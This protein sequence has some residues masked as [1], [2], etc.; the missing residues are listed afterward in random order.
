[1]SRECQLCGKRSVAA[2]NVPRRGERHYVLGR[3]KRVQRP[4][5]QTAQIEQGGRLRKIK[6]CA[7]CLRTL[8]K[9]R[10]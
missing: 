5:L 1:M 4:N 6:V 10:T 9:A 3:T 8:A 2:G 7:R